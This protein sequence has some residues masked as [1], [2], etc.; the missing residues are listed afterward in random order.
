MLPLRIV[1]VRILRLE[2]GKHIFIK[3]IKLA[4]VAVGEP[5]CTIGFIRN[6]FGCGKVYYLRVITMHRHHYRPCGHWYFGHH[7]HPD[8]TVF[9]WLLILN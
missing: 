7:K 9:N 2:T 4:A 5:V 8:G 6:A 3:N 1:L